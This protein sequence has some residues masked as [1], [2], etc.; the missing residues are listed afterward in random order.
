MQHPCSDKQRRPTWHDLA[1]RFADERECLAAFL[2]LEAAEVLDGGKPANLINVANRRRACGRN[3]YRLWQRHGASL[4]RQGGLAVRELADRGDSLLLLIYRP[5][6]LAALL[7]RPNVLGFLRKAGYTN[8]A[9][10]QT[11][12]TELQSRI[13]AAGFPH[14]IGVFLGYPLKDVAGFMGWTQLPFTC[15]GPWKIYGDPRGSLDLAEAFRQCRHRMARQLARCTTP[16]DCLKVNG[17]SAED[18][19][20]ALHTEIDC[21]YDSGRTACASR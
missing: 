14:E 6:A 12:L 5:Q 9:D 19:F 8:P 2:A 1:A 11:S 13:S 7:A 4:L 16:V 18:V 10:P 17:A 20:F 21:H 3:L 15:Q